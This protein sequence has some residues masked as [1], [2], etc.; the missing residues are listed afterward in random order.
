MAFFLFNDMKLI[1]KLKAPVVVAGLGLAGILGCSKEDP[2]R[3]PSKTTEPSENIWFNL[4][5]ERFSTSERIELYTSNVPSTYANSCDR[6]IFKNVEEI[7][8][9]HSADLDSTTA[10]GYADRFSALDRVDL[11]ANNVL[12][13]TANKYHGT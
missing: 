9:G 4:Y 10:V 7:I 8:A 5:D 2:N 6:R 12:P 11:Y 1:D 3:I 13:E